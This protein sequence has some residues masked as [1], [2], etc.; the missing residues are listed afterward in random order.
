MGT[1]GSQ[2]GDD[3]WKPTPPGGTPAP[4]PDYLTGTGQYVPEFEYPAPPVAPPLPAAPLLGPAPVHETP[5]AAPTSDPPAGRGLVITAYIFAVIALVAPC[6]FGMAGILL[7]LTANQKRH[8]RAI[9]AAYTCV[10][11][12]VAGFVL[13][14]LVRIYWL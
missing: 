6:P 13:S 4:P 1:S 5:V 3:Y 9:A 7:A 12:T 14:A 10:A 8:P 11:A 2:S